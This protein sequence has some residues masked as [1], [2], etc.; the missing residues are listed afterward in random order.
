MSAPALEKMMLAA[1]FSAIERTR[2]FTL[3][4]EPG[5]THYVS[6]RVVV[7]ARV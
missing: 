1:G 3:R 7:T 4:S 5:R 6:P 2:H